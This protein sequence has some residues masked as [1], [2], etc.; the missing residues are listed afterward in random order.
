[1]PRL[2]LFDF[3][4]RLMPNG[5]SGYE[6]VLKLGI[7]QLID[8]QKSLGEKNQAKASSKQICPNCQVVMTADHLKN[9]TTK[10]DS[11]R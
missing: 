4:F 9:P 2:G 3:S 10:Q 6:Y 11:L 1:M 5:R 8:I 7:E